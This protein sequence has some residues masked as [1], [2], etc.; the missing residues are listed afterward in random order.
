MLFRDAKKL[1]TETNVFH[2][3]Q[4]DRILFSWLKCFPD[5]NLRQYCVERP[6]LTLNHSC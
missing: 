2:K 1:F 4:L 3:F 5:K 6:T